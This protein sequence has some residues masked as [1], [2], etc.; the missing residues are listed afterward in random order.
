MSFA[1]LTKKGSL[2][3]VATVTVATVATV[4]P[5]SPSSVASVATVSVATAEKQATNEPASAELPVQENL[6]KPQLAVV[7]DLANLALENPPKPAL[8]VAANDPAQV[9]E[10]V[11]GDVLASL[12]RRE[13]SVR[14]QLVRSEVRTETLVC[15]TAAAK[16]DPDRWCWPHSQAMTGREIDTMAERTSLF[17]RRGLPALDAERLADKLVN[18]DRDGDDRHLCVECRHC[19]PGLRCVNKLAVLHVLQRCDHFVPIHRS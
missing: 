5:P 8:P 4:R 11:A 6:K 13:T 1:D 7:S 18:R 17:N 10:R 9:P 2:R 3:Q 19:R 16:F 14:K 12:L 15:S